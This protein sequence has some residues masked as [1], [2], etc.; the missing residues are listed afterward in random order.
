MPEYIPKVKNNY[1]WSIF[2]STSS[3]MPHDN[4]IEP[5]KKVVEG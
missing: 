5:N 2:I 4:P 1:V 3:W